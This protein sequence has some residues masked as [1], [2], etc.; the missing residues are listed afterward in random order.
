MSSA[1]GASHTDNVDVI[2]GTKGTIKFTGNDLSVFTTVG[3]LGLPVGEFAKIAA[4]KD[5]SRKAL[6]DD[7]ALA[8]QEGRKP[9]VPAED[10][11]LIAGTICAAYRSLLSGQPENVI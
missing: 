1:F 2:Y 4:E 7:F 5:E 8:I 9:L 11:A 3:G 10:G 6:M